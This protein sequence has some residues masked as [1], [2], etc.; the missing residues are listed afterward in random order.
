MLFADVKG[1]MDLAEQVDPEAWHR[2]L[3]RFFEILTEGVHR[4]E[5]TV[6][7]YTGDG[8]MALFGAPITHEDHAHRACYAALHLRDALRDYAEAL[9]RTEGLN[10]AVRMG[11]NSGEVVVGKIGDDLRMD[12]TAQGHTVGLAARLEQLADPGK[13]HVS[14]HTARLVAGFFRFRDLGSFQLKGVRDPVTVYELEGL[15]E[16]RT[17]LDVSRAR[18]LSQFVGRMDESRALDE[19]MARAEAGEAQAISVVAEAGVGKSRLCYEFTQRCRARGIAVREAVCV[20]HGRAIPYLP[21]LEFMRGFFGI[22]EKDDAQTARR[23]IAGT[24]LLQEEDFRD[25]LPIVFEFLG[26]PDSAQPL[27]KMDPEARRRRLFEVFGSLIQAESRR[28]PSVIV[29]EDLHWIDAGSEA[30]VKHLAKSHL[31]TKTLLLVNFRPEYDGGWLEAPFHRRIAL[32]PLGPEAITELLRSQLGDDPSLRGLG[33]HIQARTAGNPFFIEEV[34]QSLV[35]AGTLT[36]SRGAYRLE[37]PLAEIAIPPTVQTLLASRIDRLPEREKQLLQ[38]AAVIGKTFSEKVLREVAALPEAEFDDALRSL[39][40]A[41]FIY[42]ESIYPEKECAFRHPLS[43]EVAYGSQ[44]GDRRKR[45]HAAVARAIQ[46]HFAENL[47]ERAALIAHHWEQA[48]QPEDAARWHYRAAEWAGLRDPGAAFHHWRQMKAQLDEVPET[49]DTVGLSLVAR[50]QTLNFAWRMGVP[51]DEA[52]ALFRESDALAE[53]HGL[54]RARAILRFVYSGVKILAGTSGEA[55]QLGEEAFR[56]AGELGDEPLQL[57]TLGV[58]AYAIWM[59]GNPE[60]ALELTTRALAEPPAD[61]KLGSELSGFSPYI[62]AMLIHGYCLRD[63]G[64][65]EEARRSFD[66]TVRAAEEND[67]MEILSWA[68]GGLITVAQM[69]GDQ[70][71]VLAQGRR[72][73]EISDGLGSSFARVIGLWDLA[74]AHALEGNTD[75]ARSLYEEALGISRETSTARSMIPRLLAQ[76]ADVCLAQ[77]DLKTAR[78]CSDEAVS[79]VGKYLARGYEPHVLLSRARILL[80]MDGKEGVAAVRE[81]LDRAAEASEETRSRCWAP[82]IH[83]ARAALAR[84][85]GDEAEQQREMREAE[86]LHR[87]MGALGHAER[88]AGEKNA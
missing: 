50:V 88:L 34:I 29:V 84:V 47:D 6:N 77:G 58:L 31:G 55:V 42:E 80:Q 71:D 16:M 11:I 73:F 67:E 15:G 59:A 9:K 35:E 69:T 81:T 2:I 20:A 46:K 54:T 51:E 62:Y 86:R 53:R 5:G 48:A 65:F 32:H 27:P 37:K 1:S 79:A 8:I 22:T 39:A 4:F 82:F 18:G 28:Q 38:T 61:V 85:M 14:D 26:V 64:R 43:Q 68:L 57:G 76:L 87:E 60:R 25:S 72:S 44:L 7:Q 75:E 66:R 10:F 30:F 33:E 52:E 3:N 63:L 45:V 40:G 21:L 19:A 12:Y 17:R 36:G 78:K 49:P 56:M 83:E 74:T 23:N 41:G 13:I 24:L 70:E